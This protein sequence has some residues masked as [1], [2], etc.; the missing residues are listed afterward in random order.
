M[1]RSRTRLTD[2]AARESHAGYQLR[3]IRSTLIEVIV[4]LQSKCPGAKTVRPSQWIAERSRPR[5]R[6]L[7]F[8]DEPLSSIGYE[9]NRYSHSPKSRVEGDA[10]QRSY[11]VSLD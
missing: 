1:D 3:R 7:V 2:T 6:R 8:V 9:L 4:Q 10:A 5:Q 11:A